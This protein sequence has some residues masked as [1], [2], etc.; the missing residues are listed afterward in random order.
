MTVALLRMCQYP[1]C[2][3]YAMPGKSYCAEHLKAYSTQAERHRKTAWQRGYTSAWSRASKAFL[4]AHP[5]CAECQRHGILTPATEVDHIV[6]HK[7]NKQLF[8]DESNWQ[9][10]CHECHSRKTVREDGGFGNET[11]GR[12]KK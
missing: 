4:A 7:G 6:P 10:L 9:A 8:W 2:R 1:G 12:V 5:L 3:R 11:R